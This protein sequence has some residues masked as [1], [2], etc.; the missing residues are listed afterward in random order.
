MNPVVL[1]EIY[2][3]GTSTISDIQK[4]LELSYTHNLDKEDGRAHFKII[5][6]VKHEAVDKAWFLQEQA[7]SQIMSGTFLCEK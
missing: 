6:K 7:C 5:K 4:I 1:A 3:T 2:G